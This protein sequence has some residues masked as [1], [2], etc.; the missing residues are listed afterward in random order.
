MEGDRAPWQ[1]SSACN[2][3]SAEVIVARPTPTGTCGPLGRGLVA[4]FCGDA[5]AVYTHAG[6]PAGVGAFV[7]GTKT[8]R[9]F[10]IN[11][12]RSLFSAL[13]CAVLRIQIRPRCAW[14]FDGKRAQTLAALADVCEAGLSQLG[15]TLRKCSQVVPL[16]VGAMSQY[17]I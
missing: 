9:Q 6:S 4:E 11:H 16:I 13:H 15:T 10:L 3:H 14:P 1:K 17:C 7:C 5:L 12:A 8:L 2:P